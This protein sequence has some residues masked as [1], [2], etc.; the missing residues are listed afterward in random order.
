[1]RIQARDLAWPSHCDDGAGD[2]IDRL[3]QR[4]VCHA[5]VRRAQVLVAHIGDHADD[6][7]LVLDALFWEMHLPANR[8]LATEERPRGGLVENAD[9]QGART[10]LWCE[11][12]SGQQADAR[13]GKI[14]SRH[15]VEADPA[16]LLESLSGSLI[17]IATPRFQPL[18]GFIV[19][20]AAD[21]TPG[22]SCT[23]SM[24]PRQIPPSRAWSARD[25]SGV[26]GVTVQPRHRRFDLHGENAAGIE[27]G[28]DA[29][30]IVEG[31][32]EQRGA[33][34]QETPTR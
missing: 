29:V 19:A 4:Q 16:F 9:A 28:R 14:A 18:R 15:V 10:I 32:Q 24:K 22:N 1:M 33:A 2:R 6:F 3:L 17:A 34:E 12:S 13:G 20:T 30:Q 25:S 31:S 8:A 7:E 21:D 27:S 26:F 11:Q 23:R 5:A